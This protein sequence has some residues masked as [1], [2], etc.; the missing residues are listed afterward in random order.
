MS[1]EP[2]DIGVCE[3]VSAGR[4]LGIVFLAS[5]MA[6][7]GLRHVLTT[8]KDIE[9]W[10]VPGL[11][12]EI[13]GQTKQIWLRLVLRKTPGVPENGQVVDSVI[14][15]YNDPAAFLQYV[16][17]AYFR[18]EDDPEGYRLV[19]LF[20]KIYDLEYGEGPEP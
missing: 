9:W 10:A 4:V 20:D 18:L 7:W 12:S 5:D 8:R 15:L 6:I 16:F 1:E 2:V 3:I 11:K 13:T 17:G 14:S 19:P